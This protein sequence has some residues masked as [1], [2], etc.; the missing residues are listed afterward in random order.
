MGGVKVP[1]LVDTGS[2]VSTISESFFRQNFEPWGQE[3][4]QLCHW[5]QLRAA[6]GLEIPYIGYLELEVRLCGK[7]MSSC[8]VLIVRDTPGGVPSQV[9]GVLG[10][11][12]IRKCYQE[13]FG[14]HGLALFSQPCVSGSPEPVVQ[15]LQQC[16]CASTK[17]PQPSPGKVKVRG[18]R[19]WRIPGGIMKIVAATCSEAFSES[20]VLFEP[21]DVGLPAG[22]ITSP[23]LVQSDAL[24][25]V[26]LSCAGLQG[27]LLAITLIVIIFHSP[28]DRRL[29]LLCLCPMQFLHGS[30]L[31]VNNWCLH[32]FVHRR[33]DDA[34]RRGRM[35]QSRDPWALTNTAANHG[36]APSIIKGMIP[37]RQF[38]LCSMICDVTSGPVP[39]HRTGPVVV[40]VAWWWDS[41]PLVLCAVVPWA[42]GLPT[43]A[44]GTVFEKTLIGE[45]YVYP[46]VTDRGRWGRSLKKT[47]QWVVF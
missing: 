46:H 17:A 22:L 19:A 10:M 20:T 34:K 3:R 31:G 25:P 33:G 24:G 42:L 14:R 15:A 23:A 5:L 40:L 21:L 32:C 30:G 36:G 12:I 39:L 35:W 18:K 2:M 1:C 8:G 11:N 45:K 6:N 16:H 13:L 44:L 38:S 26:M 41:P 47:L 9:P 4:L 43:G 7:L 29:L 37:G 27:Q 28:V